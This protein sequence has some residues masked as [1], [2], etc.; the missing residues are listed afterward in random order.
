M[1]KQKVVM[2]D[3]DGT[4]LDTLPDLALSANYALKS[5]GF[6]EQTTEQVRM[7][8]GHGIRNLLKDLMHCEDTEILEKCRSIFQEYY[9][10]N[11]ALT[12]KPYAGIPELLQYLKDR[13]CKIILISNKYDGATQELVRQ[14]FGDIFD[15]VY[16]SRDGIAPKPDRA[17][18]DFVCERDGIDKDK[19]IYIGDSEV[20]F[21]FA[22]NCDMEFIGVSWGFRKRDQLLD[23]GAQTI[24]DSVAELKSY[25]DLSLAK[26][27]SK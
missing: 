27:K 14:F 6:P 3:L 12:T 25:L 5:L 2:F 1:N 8:I 21:E 17:I 18:F 24:A 11:K 20:D 4:V 10:K 16:G 15:G 9:N 26:Q 23:C 13:N 22:S 19:I 7:A